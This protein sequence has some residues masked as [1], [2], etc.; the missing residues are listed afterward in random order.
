MLNN[1]GDIYTTM[2]SSAALQP[3]K[4]FTPKPI[5]ARKV[6]L[7][8]NATPPKPLILS[9]KE[10]EAR[11]RARDQGCTELHTKIDYLLSTF[12]HSDSITYHQPWTL[13]GNLEGPVW[14]KAEQSDHAAD[15]IG[16]YEDV[17][18]KELRKLDNWDAAWNMSAD[19]SGRSGQNL[20]REHMKAL[21]KAPK[22]APSHTTPSPIVRL[23][24]E[25]FAQQ[26]A[27]VVEEHKKNLLNFIP[28]QE[29]RHKLQRLLQKA[30]MKLSPTRG[31]IGI[32]I[33]KAATAWEERE[34]EA[35]CT[36]EKSL[37]DYLHDFEVKSSLDL[38]MWLQ[39]WNEID[40]FDDHG[41]GE[42]RFCRFF[43][44]DFGTAYLTTPMTREE[45]SD[46]LDDD[47]YDLAGGNLAQSDDGSQ[48]NDDVDNMALVMA[49]LPTSSRVA[50]RNLSLRGLRQC[51]YMMR[52][53]FLMTMYCTRTT[54]VH[55]PLIGQKSKLLQM[56]TT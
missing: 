4:K 41:T 43:N 44:K 9:E 48:Q 24:N 30:V 49:L 29:L 47:L 53:T 37:E 33:S 56:I 2:D 18:A 32:N 40:E 16:S 34:W 19:R 55:L 20:F 36:K 3:S 52:A 38:E 8:R 10:L 15:V 22:T 7:D 21:S 17:V 27:Q 13:T 11:K 46:D 26:A 14:T 1:V 42:D 23:Q 5:R 6:A 31:L 12:P 45:T 50:I 28:R 25:A 51:P 35:A 54:C 39:E